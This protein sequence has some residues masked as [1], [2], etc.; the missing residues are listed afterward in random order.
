MRYVLILCLLP[1]LFGAAY[2]QIYGQDFMGPMNNINY[3]SASSTLESG[4]RDNY[5]VDNLTDRTDRS[6]AEGAAGSGVGEYFVIEFN[7]PTSIAGF[8]LRNGYGNL[9][10]YAGNNRVKSFR[11]VFDHDASELVEVKDSFEFEQYRFSQAR[12][13]STVQF[14]INEVYRGTQYNDACIAEVIMLSRPITDSEVKRI[15]DVRHDTSLER[16]RAVNEYLDIFDFIPFSTYSKAASLDAPSTLTLPT[17]ELPHIDGATALYPV[18]ASFV[19]AVYPRPAGET[20]EPDRLNYDDRIVSCSRTEQAYENLIDGKADL[21][22]CYEPSKEHIKK[23]EEK[24]L[25]FNLTPIGRD[26]FVFF[27]NRNNPLSGLTQRQIRDLY[28]GRV[29]NWQSITGRNE[30][31]IAYQRPENSGS[32][33]VLQSIMGREP[34]MEPMWEYIAVEMGQSVDSVAEYYNYQSAIG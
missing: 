9:D 20:Y 32:Q 5:H 14:I 17:T 12:N 25:R 3:L 33:T 21:I 15:A 23:A 6:W 27:V 22:F 16:P 19:Q 2:G 8:A 24:G 34:V 18:Y 10:F 29:R 1:G 28:S 4:R 13:C 31:V 11:V 30:P 7:S 26:A